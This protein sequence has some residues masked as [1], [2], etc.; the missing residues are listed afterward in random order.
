MKMSFDLHQLETK[1]IKFSGID[2]TGLGLLMHHQKLGKI[3]D[4]WCLHIPVKDR[5]SFTGLLQLVESTIRSEYSRSPNRPIYLV[6]ES[7]GGCLALAVS[8]R[9]PDIDLLL[10][11]SNPGKN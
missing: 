11:L 9:N 10:I 4:I 6:G 2:G 8:N 3:F 5:T 7:L 1:I